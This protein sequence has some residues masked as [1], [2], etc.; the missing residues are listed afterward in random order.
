MMD[1]MYEMNQQYHKELTM[2]IIAG[3]LRCKG[4]ARRSC[5]GSAGRTGVREN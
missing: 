4:C 5:P 1:K 2:Y 3:K